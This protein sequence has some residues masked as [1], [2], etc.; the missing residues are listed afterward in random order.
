[1]KIFLIPFITMFFLGLNVNAGEPISGEGESFAAEYAQLRQL[2]GKVQTKE[3]AITYKSQIAQELERLKSS[4]INGGQ[5]FDAL[6]GE[7]KQAFIKKFQNNHF[8]CGE[9]TQVMEERRRILLDPDLSPILS[10]LM[11]KIP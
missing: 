10:S 2:L 1:M 8:H 7:Q 3:S 6:S 4:Q 11:H 9:V 5:A